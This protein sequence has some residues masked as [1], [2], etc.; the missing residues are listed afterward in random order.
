MKMLNEILA[1]AA[2]VIETPHTPTREELDD[3]AF[4]ES[5]AKEYDGK[6]LQ[7]LGEF[8]IQERGKH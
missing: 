3:I 5:F 2:K 1:S 6:L 7:A 4:A 8:L